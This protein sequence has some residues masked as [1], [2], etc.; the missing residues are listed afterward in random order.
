METGGLHFSVELPQ[1]LAYAR[2]LTVILWLQLTLPQHPLSEEA[3]GSACHAV[4][5]Q[6]E[7]SGKLSSGWSC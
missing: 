7:F 5:G 4:K 2:P 1:H 3:T 6:D